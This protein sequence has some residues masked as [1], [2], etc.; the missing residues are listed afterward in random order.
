MYEITITTMP[1][2]ND[3][4]MMEEGYEHVC[5][6][7]DLVAD[8]LTECI[9]QNLILNLCITDNN[10]AW[11]DITTYFAVDAES[12]QRFV[13]KWT[14]PD[15]EFSMGKFWKMLNWSQTTNIKEID[16]SDVWAQPLVESDKTLLWSV[17]EKPF[18]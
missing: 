9:E 16:F 8:W 12:A 7:W 13:D 5:A 10:G 14:D 1:D 6:H 11:P 2:V 4:T 3:A 18:S 17:F 15:A